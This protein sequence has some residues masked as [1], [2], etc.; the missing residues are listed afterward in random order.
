MTKDKLEKS[1]KR[2][3]FGVT[4]WL[5]RHHPEFLV[6]IRYLVRFHRL[7]NLKNPQT[8][9]EKILYLSLRTDTHEW[10]RL[11]DKYKVRKYLEECGLGDTLVTL[12][13]VW[14]NVNEIDFDKL[15]QSFVLKST[16]GCGDLIIVKD[17]SELN[18]DK[19]R[20]TLAR[21]I[22]TPYGELEGGI[23]YMRIERKVIAEELLI[24][25]PVSAKYSKS[26]IDFKVWCFNGK[27]HYIMVCFNRD[28]FGLDAMLY[29]LDWNAHPEYCVFSSHFREGTVISRPSNLEQ[30]L[31]TAEK[32][33]E[34]FPVVRVDLYDICDRIYFGEMTF[35]SLGGLMN[36]FSNDFLNRCG[37]LIDLGK[38]T[39]L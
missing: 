13:G 16:N 38:I 31:S 10:T 21:M 25:D 26:L 4:K 23:H 17:K 33:A 29:D 18:V 3:L 9:N 8:L 37:D 32:L 11:A 14:D 30:L 24:N 35:T 20:K 19:T 5:G 34:G 1:I 15:P 2:P 7:L 28:C 36:Y 22:Q 39:Y 6:R 27:A 12:Y